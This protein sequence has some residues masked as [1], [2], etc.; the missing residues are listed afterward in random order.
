MNRYIDILLKKMSDNNYVNGE[1]K[2]E[3]IYESEKTISFKA[4]DEARAISNIEYLDDIYFRIQHEKDLTTKS[5]LY[6]ILKHIGINTQNIEATS[7]LINRIV[8]EKN[9]DM[10]VSILCNL[11]E[12][13]KPS[14]IDISPII[15]CMD[16]RSSRVRG[17][18][19]EALINSEY[20]VEELL[21]KKLKNNKNTD[22]IVY[23]IRA[24]QYVATYKSKATIEKFLK[25]R[26]PVINNVATYAMAI[27]LLRENIAIDYVHKKTKISVQTLYD[28]N[29]KLSIFT[30]RP[31][32]LIQ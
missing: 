18:A 10:L 20:D 5:N 22:D 4:F 16:N 1:I 19:Y 24:I 7:F 14:I 13:Y 23:L 12:L 30:R 2:I 28:L 9:K 8:I 25:S 27:L 15:K 21:L 3:G 11:S 6:F 17:M 31:L 29:K 32:K 26:K